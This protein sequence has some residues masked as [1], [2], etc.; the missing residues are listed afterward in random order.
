MPRKRS[1]IIGGENDK[2]HFACYDHDIKTERRKKIMSL[3][4]NHRIPLDVL[5]TDSKFI[6]RSVVPRFKYENGKK[7][8]TVE[9]Y[10]Y[11]VVNAS[12][13]DDMR[14]VVPGTI[15]VM[16]NEEIVLLRESGTSVQL[17]FANAT[18]QVYVN[19]STHHLEESIKADSVLV[20]DV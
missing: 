5:L 18:V 13:F 20:V 19:S 9:G 6:L 1:I 17:E 7:T 4:T 11:D 16:T 14:I 10:V 15:P 8:D 3:I 12:T 2:A